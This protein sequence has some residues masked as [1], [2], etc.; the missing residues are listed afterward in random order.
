MRHAILETERLWL[1]EMTREDG[2]VLHRLFSDP[3]AMVHYP[4]PFTRDMTEGWIAWS[5]RNY[6]EHGFGLWAVVLKAD[7]ALVGD[8]G[9]TFQRIDGARELEIGYHL[10]PLAWGNGYATEAALACRDHAFDTLG[11]D[12]VV[13]RMKVGNTASR[14]VAERVGMRLE[15]ELEDEDGARTVV[16]SMGP[17]DRQAAP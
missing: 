8:C 2:D 13:S 10:L 17:H 3:V 7:G 9:L 12:R 11:R 4:K 6:R 16:Y 15:K 5:Q 14:R 1:R